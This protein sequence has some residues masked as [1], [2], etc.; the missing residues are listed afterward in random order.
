M[1]IKKYKHRNRADFIKI[2]SMLLINFALKYVYNESE[3]PPPTRRIDFFI[4][5][6][7]MMALLSMKLRI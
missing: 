2:F 5:L 1:M 3:K 6:L 4:E 7:T